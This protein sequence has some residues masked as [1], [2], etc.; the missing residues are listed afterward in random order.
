MSKTPVRYPSIF[1][2]DGEGLD[3]C[4]E[5]FAIQTFSYR[6]ATKGIMIPQGYDHT[7]SSNSSFDLGTW[8]S[9]VLL[10]DNLYLISLL[11]Y[12]PNEMVHRLK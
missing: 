8:A 12:T 9:S 11:N 7:F 1:F 3:I 6:F 10:M 5:K 4:F 2:Y